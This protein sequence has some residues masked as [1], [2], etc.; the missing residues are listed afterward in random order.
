MKR[1]ATQKSF[2]NLIN[3]IKDTPIIYRSD[4]QSLKTSKKTATTTSAAQNECKD[5]EQKLKWKKV[6]AVRSEYLMFHRNAVN[7]VMQ[8]AIRQ[9]CPVGEPICGTQIR[10]KEVTTRA[11]NTK[12]CT[13]SKHGLHLVNGN[14]IDSAVPESARNFLFSSIVF[15]RKMRSWSR[16]EEVHAISLI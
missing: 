7:T 10:N 14:Q 13:M 6:Y 5:H 15:K 12:Y 16:R 1:A 11:L 8:A 3:H 4:S 2:V 9:W